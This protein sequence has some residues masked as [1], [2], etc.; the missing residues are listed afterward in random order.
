MDA[1]LV[2]G[3]IQGGAAGMVIIVVV[4][5]LKHLTSQQTNSI[6]EHT[7]MMAFIAE[8]RQD[9]HEAVTTMAVTNATAISEAIKNNSM[10]VIEAAKV[11][12]D[13]NKELV[14]MSSTA[15]TQI[16]TAMSALTVEIRI[17]KEAQL[18][19]DV[20]TKAAFSEMRNAKGH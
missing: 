1:T 11:A 2:T 20:L 12:S 15:Y 19:H 10:A 14:S 3:L 9:N 17:L 16:A 8:Q 5:F 6:A 13:S 18:A 7:Q 4:I